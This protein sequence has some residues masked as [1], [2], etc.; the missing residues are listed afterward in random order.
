MPSCASRTA[1]HTTAPI[2]GRRHNFMTP[3]LGEQIGQNARR[4]DAYQRFV[5]PFVREGVLLVIDAKQMLNRRVNI[6][7]AAFEVARR[8]I[9]EFV[10]LAIVEPRFQTGA[11]HPHAEAVRIVVA[12]GLGVLRLDSGQTAKLAG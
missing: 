12:A 1:A 3:S 2:A 10:G 4:S 6:A 9:S 11:R 5:P 7:M 8:R